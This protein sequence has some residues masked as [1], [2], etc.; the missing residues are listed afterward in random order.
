[1]PVLD[2]VKECIIDFYKYFHKSTGFLVNETI[3]RPTH[4]T[5]YCELK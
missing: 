3:N 1:M 2:N 5:I 4:T